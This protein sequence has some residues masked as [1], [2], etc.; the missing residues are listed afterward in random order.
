MKSDLEQE[1]AEASLL[2]LPRTLL[3]TLDRPSEWPN[4][5]LLLH[6]HFEQHARTSPD[7]P[8][9]A[10]SL[11]DP[12]HEGVWQTK[13]LTYAQLNERADAF[14]TLLVQANGGWL[15]DEPVPL[16]IVQSV[17][18]YIAIL[19]ILKAGGAWCP[20]DPG[21]PVQR[22]RRLIQRTGAKL[23]VLQEGCNGSEMTANLAVSVVFVTE[24]PVSTKLDAS[25]RRRPELSDL[26]YLIWTSGSTGEP[27][28]VLIEHQAAS[29]AMKALQDTIPAD[30]PPRT[31][32]FS[33][34]T[35]DIHIQDIFYTWGLG[36]CV[37]AASR[38]DMIEHMPAIVAANGV[39]HAHL[40]PAFGATISRTTCPSL[41]VV[42]MIGEKLTE[43]VASNWSRDVLFFNTYGPAESTVVSTVRQ[44]SDSGELKKASNIGWP[45]PSVSLAVVR[46]GVPVP[47]GGVGELALAGPHLARGYL[48]DE[49]K[50]S[51]Q[52]IFN[53]SI[54]QRI[55]LTGDM[56][57][58][59]HDGSLDFL[60][61]TDD[62]IKINGV[63]I[64]LSEISRTMM[65]CHEHVSNIETL[66]LS[67]PDRPQ[68]VLVCFLCAD[69]AAEG[70]WQ[71]MNI[72]QE[73]RQEQIVRS[74]RRLAHERLPTYMRPVCYIIVKEIPRSPSAKVDTKKLAELYLAA[75]LEDSADGSNDT[76]VASLVPLALEGSS[77]IVAECI[78]E[79]LEVPVASVACTQNLASLGLDSIRCIRLSANLKKK[80][81]H[82]SAFDLM[83]LQTLEGIC[84]KVSK[85]QLSKVSPHQQ[86]FLNDFQQRYLA[87]SSAQLDG[88]S[89]QYVAPV[90]PLQESLLL[91]TSVHGEAYWSTH[92]FHL[93][94]DVD[95]QR[96]RNAWDHVAQETEILRA[97]FLPM[98][99]IDPQ[100][101]GFMHCVYRQA[102]IDWREAKVP[103]GG[104]SDA[105]RAFVSEVSQARTPSWSGQLGWA[106]A[107]FHD[108]ATSA[109]T[110]A[111]VM[112][113]ALYDQNALQHLL[114]HVRQV[115]LAV[116]QPAYTQLSAA[117]KLGLAPSRVQQE[118][119]ASYWRQLLSSQVDASQMW[120]LPDLAGPKKSAK[121]TGKMNTI[122][123][124]LN[125]DKHTMSACAQNLDMNS[126]APLV[127]AAFAAILSE[128]LAQDTIL[129]GTTISERSFY[130]ELENA[131]APLI[132]TFPFL[133]KRTGTCGDFLKSLAK[134]WRQSP[135]H[136][137]I[138]GNTIRKALSWPP[139]RPL[140]PAFFVF[141]PEAEALQTSAGDCELWT[142]EEKDSTPLKVDHA[143]ALNLY[144]GDKMMMV[145]SV[146]DTVM[147][148]SHVELFAKQIDAQLTA[149]LQ[150]LDTPLTALAAHLPCNLLSTSPPTSSATNIH[151]YYWVQCHA[152]Q[153]PDWLAVEEV[154][155]DFSV[156]SWTYKQLDCRVRQCA[157]LLLSHVSQ[158]DPVIAVCMGR[159]LDSFAAIL[160]IFFVGG[161]YLPIAE[162]LPVERKKF[163]VQ[164]SAASVILASHDLAEPFEE[165][166]VTILAMDSPKALSS[167]ETAIDTTVECGSQEGGYLLY[168]SGSTGTPKGVRATSRNLSCFVEG[169]ASLILR[170]S[171]R[172][173]QLG[174]R[175]KQ[176]NLASRAFDP[177]LSQM[178]VSW[179]LGLCATTGP[180]MLLLD[181][182]R[183]T[184]NTLGITH[185]G[186]LPSMLDQ[187]GLLPVD[188][189]SLAMLSV[190]GEKMSA[191]VIETWASSSEVTIFNLY[192]PTETT[193]GCTLSLVT[194]LSSPR[195]IGYPIGNSSALVVEPGT[196]H[197]VK[198]GQKGELCI[199]GD[200]VTKG[201][202]RPVPS[203]G[204][205][206]LPDG[207]PAYRTGDMVQMMADRSL[208]FLGRNDEQ[209]KIRGQRLE[210]SEVTECG[211]SADVSSPIVAATAYF[212]H[213]QQPT[214]RLFTFFSDK[215]QGNAAHNFRVSAIEGGIL[216]EQIARHCREQLPAFMV[217]LLVRMEALPLLPSGKI[218]LKRIVKAFS[219]SKFFDQHAC[220]F[221]MGAE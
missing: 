68:R 182:L 54:G 200:L 116:L 211:L 104:V 129:V 72:T 174:G 45:L 167:L 57:R 110:M 46:G 180:R 82:A 89:L 69:Q 78:S 127:Q 53:H 55:Y 154:R 173:G 185:M 205:C 60:G 156:H 193:I 65:G 219:A 38:R 87:V 189:P 141:H 76:A 213:P 178:F 169:Y 158:P 166:S 122:R 28:G 59:L 48:Q 50:T 113:H 150:R 19:G 52:F 99:E 216:A 117:L 22:Q 49:A 152:E 221:V 168:T 13:S 90:S 177:H 24:R 14:A 120:S 160:S 40:T 36:G 207:T 73:K 138:S 145:L 209:I 192:G 149:M 8:A 93:Q 218:D 16:C 11:P 17:E 35:F 214:A 80:G 114:H 186:I 97:S 70:D 91:E 159:T 26:A 163:L 130:P 134:Q 102:T 58:M 62:M 30:S 206:S 33:A 151:P 165:L 66:Y 111:L 184:I 51:S 56:V 9:L 153:H 94:D 183:R 95:M 170:H 41:R 47:R 199:A 203:T 100:G 67:R 15:Q 23:L 77:K 34:F 6:E 39:T 143:F 96:L 201:Y 119:S 128:H 215:S 32:Q 109:K 64:E 190:G 155:Q 7:H 131:I 118:E 31:L 172:T 106:L 18:L 162:D 88:R 105:V 123:F 212:R 115:Y 210:L 195:N 125:M 208:E 220:E 187:S 136:R 92:L 37:V 20:I 4:P 148:L 83:Q 44:I 124:E 126:C 191:H 161:V 197:V 107:I 179:R 2:H 146:A 202:L 137:Q 1:V 84:R 157:K 10:F 21:F 81:L 85:A 142:R 164:D 12:L 133:I 121:D 63:R 144:N 29:T 71:S 139:D 25:R 198:L 140:Y 86:R 147:S 3:S 108:V 27:K 217:P 175:G 112:H 75:S 79:I 188:V 196:L 5:T 61:R 194:P 101:R 43:D 171:A 74:A 98:A 204:F 132:S 103:V 181:D 135:K 42:T 176:L